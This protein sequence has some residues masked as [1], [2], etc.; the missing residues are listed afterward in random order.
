M[1]KKITTSVL[2]IL[3]ISSCATPKA[4]DIMQANDDM[5]SCNELRLAFEKA[6][7]SEDEAHANK[8]VTNENILSGL[9]FF[10]AYFVTYGSSIHAEYNASERKEHLLKL[11]NKKGCAKPKSNEYQKLVSETLSKLEE[12]KMKYSQGIIDEENYFEMRRQL[13]VNFN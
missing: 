7:L 4:M 5:M 2:M 11:Y 6:S 12:L 9:F 1:I 8:G 10:P 13:L 3:L